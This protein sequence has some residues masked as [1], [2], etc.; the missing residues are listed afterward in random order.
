M[1]AGD[2]M[3]AGLPFTAPWLLAPMEGVTDRVY[4]GLILARNGPEHLGGVTTEFLRVLERPR[5][6]L[7]VTRPP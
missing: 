6:P 5:H 3:P 7:Y 2:D 1:D 4:R